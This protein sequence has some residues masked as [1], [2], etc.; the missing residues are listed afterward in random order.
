MAPLGPPV[1]GLLSWSRDGPLQAALPL[2]ACASSG[3]PLLC[4]RTRG[5]GS[6]EW[7]SCRVR[8]RAPARER[9][10]SPVETHIRNRR[11]RHSHLCDCS[12]GPVCE[13]S[14]LCTARPPRVT[15]SS[16]SS[17]NSRGGLPGEKGGAWKSWEEDKPV[18]GFSRTATLS[19][20]RSWLGTLGSSR[21]ARK[22]LPAPAAQGPGQL[23]RPPRAG[24][25]W[26]SLPLFNSCLC[27]YSKLCADLSSLTL[28]AS[29]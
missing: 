27:F 29:L 21:P 12:W 10:F 6:C 16:S 17:G 22:A 26:K 11:A 20:A 25:R 4:P 15:S 28:Q 18:Q 24:S 2:P 23:V 9:L 19:S 7:C 8:G 5:A 1:A 14:T 3:P 13:S